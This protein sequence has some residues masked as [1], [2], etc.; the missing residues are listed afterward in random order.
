MST[1][2]AN[3]LA[4]DVILLVHVLFVAF[5]IGSLVAILLGRMLGWE[6][7]R[8]P[9]FRLVHL[10]SIGIVVVQ[11]W[12]GMICPLTIWEN[13]FRAKAGDETYTGSFVAHWLETL[14]YYDAPAWVFAVAY[15][16]FGAGVVASWFWVR[17]RPFFGQSARVDRR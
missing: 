2:L 10:A 7:V 14:L 12:F 6:W 11:A 15:S 16:L 9:W 1:E 13:S 17:P 3:L 4:A 5:V 8:N